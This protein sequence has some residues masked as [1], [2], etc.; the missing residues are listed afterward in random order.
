MTE[1]PQ[2]GGAIV[3]QILLDELA[4]QLEAVAAWYERHR[5]INVPPVSRTARIR[6]RLACGWYRLR[7][8]FA[9]LIL[10]DYPWDEL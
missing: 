4:S 7:K 5:D 3:P 9:R 10:P 8:M 1:E 2:P 6:W